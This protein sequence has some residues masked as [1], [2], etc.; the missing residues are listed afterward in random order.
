MRRIA[1]ALTLILS[2]SL[3]WPF[4]VRSHGEHQIDETGVEIRELGNS[5]KMW[6]GKSLPRYPDTQPEVKILDIKIPKGISLPWHYHP[7]IN[8][9]V[10]LQGRLELKLTDG[11][12]KIFS[13]GEA[14]VEVVNTV[15]SGKALG[16]SDVH[17]I[18]FYAGEN[19]IP[20]TIL[21]KKHIN[22]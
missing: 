9:A 1:L 15:H 16:P 12:T 8:A 18:V 6:N 3:T 13:K 4:L 21:Y 19:G 10:I 2:S 14:L 20:S 5:S 22:P 17:L 11:T 7:V